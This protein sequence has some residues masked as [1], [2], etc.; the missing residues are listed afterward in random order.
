MHLLL[1]SVDSPTVRRLA[2]LLGVATLL[3]AGCGGARVVAPTAEEVVGTLPKTA[4]PKTISL[5][6]GNPAMGKTLFAKL[7]CGTCHTYKPAGTSGT[8]G[9]DL[10]KLA[11][12]AAKANRGSLTQFTA[13]SIVDPSA[14][15]ESGFQDVMPK[16]FAKLPKT[17]IA[18][19]VAFLTKK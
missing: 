19:L 4:G 1:A 7:N 9:P 8:I 10:D 17:Q 2:V 18:D 14:Y 11:S 6:K 13:E 5:P 15:V 3:V 12:Y 16:T